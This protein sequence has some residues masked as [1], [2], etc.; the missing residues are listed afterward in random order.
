VGISSQRRRARSDEA[1]LREAAY[2]A[3]GVAVSLRPPF[4]PLVP[5]L[6]GAEDSPL[7]QV[8]GLRVRYPGTA[9]SLEVASLSVQAGECV[10]LLGP[11][12]SGKSTLLRAIKGL[13]PLEAGRVELSH[14]IEADCPSPA[15]IALIYQQFHL[16][17][18]ATVYENILVGCLGRVPKW[19]AVLGLF[20]RTERRA[21]VA[22]ALEVG[23][24][25]Q[26][27]AR[28]DRTS[29]GQQQRV[30]IARAIVQRARLVLADEPVAS[31]DPETGKQVLEVLLTAASLH[32]QGLL[33]SLHDPALA[34]ATCT[35]LLGL[36]DGLVLFD[37]PAGRVT[38]AQLE[39]LYRRSVTSD[40]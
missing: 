4:A 14:G 24:E 11:S 20:P 3:S 37:T 34:R 6:D 23:L 21:A 25:E 5:G 30:A 39:E 26:L 17:G 38:D 19:R 35:R 7:L 15:E 28:A 33:I 10:G 29:G 9:F 22:A 36:R 18:R 2:D 12:G 13:V 16:V 8:A 1:I 31:L 32:D 27:L 40:E